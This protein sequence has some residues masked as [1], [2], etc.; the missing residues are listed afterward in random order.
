MTLTETVAEVENLGRVD[1]VGSR[2]RGI[3]THKVTRRWHAQ[4]LADFEEANE[5]LRRQVEQDRLD[6]IRAICDASGLDFEA[7]VHKYRKQDAP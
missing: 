6:M 5:R 7:Q 1:S 3:G 2:H 4:C